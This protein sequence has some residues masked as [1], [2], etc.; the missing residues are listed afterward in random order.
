MT[1]P[2]PAENTFDHLRRTRRLSASGQR[3]EV[4]RDRGSAAHAGGSWARSTFSETSDGGRR[5]RFPAVSDLQC[6]A[7]VVLMERG[8]PD[9]DWLSRY[10]TAGRF[11]AAG[12]TDLRSTLDGIADE[13]RG[14]T[15]VV[16]AARADL[17]ELLGRLGLA[18][19][20]P[21]VLDIDADG[22]R[23]APA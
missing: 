2:M 12:G 23:P 14:E 18:A 6:P 17:V 20:L 3:R 4:R 10:R 16:S 7:T 1:K 9:P 11:D 13:Y 15:V 22:W 19:R 8:M 5:S 21:A